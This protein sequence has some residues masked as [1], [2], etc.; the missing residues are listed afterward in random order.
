MN[1]CIGVPAAS[2]RVTSGADA[3]ERPSVTRERV[4]WVREVA[5]IPERGCEQAASMA[6]FTGRR[7]IAVGAGRVIQGAARPFLRG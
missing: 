5:V 7:K 3:T 1:V 6:F 2:L 4:A